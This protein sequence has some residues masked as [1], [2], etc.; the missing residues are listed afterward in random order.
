MTNY[1]KQ[2]LP[3]D[4]DMISEIDAYRFN[5]MCQMRFN[6]SEIFQNR[7][8]LYLKNLENR[9]FESCKDSKLVKKIVEEIIFSGYHT[10]PGSFWNLSEKR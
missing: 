6:D 8:N 7:Y 4:F 2:N 10:I 3:E 5:L 1:E 9:L